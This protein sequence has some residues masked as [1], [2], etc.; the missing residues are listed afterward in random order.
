MPFIALVGRPNVG[1]STIFNRLVGQQAA[2]TSDIPGTT[3][4]RHFGV[5]KWFN[6][7]WTIV[8]TAGL[9]DENL[10]GMTTELADEIAEQIDI[11]C[12]QAQLIALVVDAKGVPSPE[13]LYLADVLRKTN[14]PVVLLANKADNPTYR[15]LAEQYGSLGIKPIFA[16]SAIHGSGIRSFVDYLIENFPSPVDASAVHEPTITFVGRPNVGKSTLLNRLL[17]YKRSAVSST[18]GTTRDTVSDTIIMPSGKKVGVIDTA[19]VRR[20]GKIEVGIEKFSMVRTLRAISES[21]VVVVLITLEEAPSRGDAHIVNFALEANKKVFLAINKA[22]LLN[23]NVFDWTEH[24]RHNFAMRFV[25]RFV[26]LSRLP[27]VLISAQSGN[28]V[29]E[30]LAMIDEALETKK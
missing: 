18:P 9:V 26:F 15:Q 14:K 1:K 12:E 3:R 27:K 6:H 20:R 28:G 19:G 29:K 22:D 8:D 17:G 10:E 16:T 23:Q 5:A 24:K 21:D 2:I 30:L 4:D 7:E 25:S 11:A 13:D